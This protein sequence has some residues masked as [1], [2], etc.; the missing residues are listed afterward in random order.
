MRNFA[1]RSVVI[2]VITL[3]FLVLLLS[4]GCAGVKK[5]SEEE[6]QVK[7]KNILKQLDKISLEDNII[8]QKDS[9]LGRFLSNIPEIPEFALVYAPNLDLSHTLKKVS[10]RTYH[11][12]DS[13][14]LNGRIVDDFYSK[15][16]GVLMFRGSFKRDMPVSGNVQGIPKKII[17]DWVYNT[18][19]NA[20]KTSLGIWGGGLGWT[21]QPL[22]VN[23][24]DTLR[25]SFKA[26]SDDFKSKNSVPE[27]I[28]G[29]LSGTVFFLDFETGKETRAPIHTNNPIK[30][31][32]SVDPR[33]NG[34]LYIGNGVPH[35]SEFGIHMINLHKHK[36][37]YFYSGHTESVA[38]RRWGAFDSS[39]VVVGDYLY[40]P[41]ENGVFYK[42][43][44]NNGEIKLM[45]KLVYRVSGKPN[46]GIESSLA[47]YKNYGY[48]GDNNG[49]ILCVNLLTM[50][51]VWHYD[52][53]D[54]TDASIVI[55]V[56]DGVPYLYTSCQID[57]QPDEGYSYFTKLNGLDG[58]KV[59]TNKVRAY[60]VVQGK[61]RSD[62]GMFSTPLIGKHNANDIIITNITHTK[63]R[64]NG[65][66]IAFYK[67]TGKIA[68]R[69]HLSAY[70]WSS[71]V[72]FYNEV[73][74]LYI[75]T[76]DVIGNAYL[77]DGSNGDIIYK[78]NVGH[79]FEASP[80]AWGNSVVIGS[81]GRQIYRLTIE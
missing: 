60:A 29:S 9:L 79:N 38:Y 71:P 47:V 61:S 70:S 8:F 64:R 65:E 77:I 4:G 44:V 18:D 66:L 58:T 42:Y 24:P 81:R 49:N 75:F 72:A 62:G 10:H 68:Y 57:K 52:N 17:I 12:Y 59:W 41:G 22:L 23:W 48:F 50:K 55:E 73:G 28:L 3:A 51:P 78:R 11:Y 76:G 25:Q 43:S 56:E 54:D 13:S 34:M 26:L 1:F 35:T 67:S 32:P 40:W 16:K 36:E 7:H 45:S 33:F 30:G 2:P 69:T 6:T 5:L 39:P 21:G 27:V 63:K 53:I 31:T 20:K 14:H 46:Y 19:F 74:D 80:V 15:E 37:Q